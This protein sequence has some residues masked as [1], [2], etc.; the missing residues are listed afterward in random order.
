MKATVYR[1]A[2][3]RIKSKLV[4]EIDQ[5]VDVIAKTRVQ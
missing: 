2:T 3:T 4:V 5:I 1:E